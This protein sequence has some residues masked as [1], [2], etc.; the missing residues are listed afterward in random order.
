MANGDDDF[1]LTIHCW[2][3]SCPQHRR[4]VIPSTVKHLRIWPNRASKEDVSAVDL[5][6]FPQGLCSLY[7]FDGGH[8][9][10]NLP[11]LSGLT[12]LKSLKLGALRTT[13]RLQLPDSLVEFHFHGDLCILPDSIPP[14]LERVSLT[15]AAT[16]WPR[17][18][19]GRNAPPLYMSDI[20][21]MSIWRSQWNAAMVL[22]RCRCRVNWLALYAMLRFLLT[23]IRRRYWSPDGDG[24]KAVIARGFV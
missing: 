16:I 6:I 1:G 3:P 21:P 11:D 2:T 12:C 14:G 23:A 19:N 8:E 24:G 4:L 9:L 7:F 17:L 22:R 10:V 15:E 13:D 5:P 20:G 18:P